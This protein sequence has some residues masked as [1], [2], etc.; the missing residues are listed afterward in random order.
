MER[1]LLLFFFFNVLLCTNRNQKSHP[2]LFLPA[3]DKL[4]SCCCGLLGAALAVGAE[5][6]CCPCPGNQIEKDHLGQ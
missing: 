6:R 2:G 3:T 4:P 5:E 1:V